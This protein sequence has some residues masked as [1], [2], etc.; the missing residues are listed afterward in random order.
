MILA[1]GK[2]P[3]ADSKPKIGEELCLMLREMQGEHCEAKIRE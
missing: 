2:D 1:R 3:N